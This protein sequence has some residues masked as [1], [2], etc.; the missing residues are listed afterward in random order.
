MKDTSSLTQSLNGYLG[1]NKARI[2]CFVRM[3]LGLLAVKT[4]NLQEIAL[5]FGGK[6]K[7]ESNYRRLQ[8]FFAFFTID[9]VQIARWIF[10]LYV[11]P[12]QQF[13]L[14]IDRTN[15]YWGKKKN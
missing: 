4:V 14:V 1:L 3:L 10:K 2:A 7:I 9:F 6:A 15:W 13:Y 12:D 5:A 11:H 8:R